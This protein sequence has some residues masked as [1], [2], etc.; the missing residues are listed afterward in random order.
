[1][2]NQIFVGDKVK[3]G[4]LDT[5]YT[6]TAIVGEQASLEYDGCNYGFY[7]L[8]L[9][10]KLPNTYAAFFKGNSLEV[11]AFTSFEAQ[12][13]AAEKFGATSRKYLVSVVLIAKA[14][15]QVAIDTASL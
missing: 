8:Y 3:V 2:K 14:G 7:D 15:E 4:E 10:T 1:M 6:V 5:V 12:Q 9:L 13:L 11:E